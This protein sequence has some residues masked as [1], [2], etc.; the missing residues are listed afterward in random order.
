M[1]TDPAA[2]VSDNASEGVLS[3]GTTYTLKFQP[4][5]GAVSVGGQLNCD[6][7]LVDASQTIDAAAGLAVTYSYNHV[8]AVSFT[9][10]P[11]TPHGYQVLL[12]DETQT[13]AV[14]FDSDDLT[15]PRNPSKFA[16]N[17]LVDE[18]FIKTVSGTDFVTKSWSYQ[19]KRKLYDQNN[20]P[21][22][23]G[24]GVS[25]TL[26]V[27]VT[28]YKA[29]VAVQQEVG[30][31]ATVRVPSGAS[32]SLLNHVKMT[33]A[34]AN[35]TNSVQG[36]ASG[37]ESTKNQFYAFVTESDATNKVDLIYFY[38]ATNLAGLGSADFTGTLSFLSGSPSAALRLPATSFTQSVITGTLSIPVVA[39][40]YRPSLSLSTTFTAATGVTE[41]TSNVSL[42]I[43]DTRNQ[44]VP[45]TMATLANNTLTWN[46]TTLPPGAYS[47]AITA[48]PVNQYST[49]GNF[50][51]SGTFN[52][53][54]APTITNAIVNGNTFGV[55]V[56]PNG[57]EPNAAGVIEIYVVSIATPATPSDAALQTAIKTANCVFDSVNRAYVAT[58]NYDFVVSSAI[59][60]A[61]TDIGANVALFS[62]TGVSSQGQV[63]LASNEAF[64]AAF[65]A[66]SGGS[67]PVNNSSGSGSTGYPITTS[68]VL[69]TLLN[70]QIQS[71]STAQIA[72]ITSEQLL[73]LDAT[74]ANYFNPPQILAMSTTQLASI[75]KS[76]QASI[77]AI[78]IN[79][80][81]FTQAQKDALASAPN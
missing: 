58:F 42:Q 74:H 7:L 39:T 80:S 29:L 40:N 38:L 53:A 68:T 69:N 5:K 20:T 62:S 45:V 1:R 65:N 28:P 33:V 55:V 47:Y 72:T 18:T 37:S 52:I 79:Q 44:S 71:L 73:A 66:G 57:A 15:V 48:S 63:S 2:V 24:V 77:Q 8:S 76:I 3:A 35:F 23:R 17:L 75:K 36:K 21:I 4:F 34:G 25:E 11:N 51:R 70:T 6:S 50:T 30:L 26:H 64:L 60:V 27:D 12:L 61:G 46:M 54:L 31:K 14:M 13:A 9:T 67:V 41:S 22:G 43:K 78:T 32:A 59:L 49:Y 10:A 81:Q 19:I 56:S 16:N